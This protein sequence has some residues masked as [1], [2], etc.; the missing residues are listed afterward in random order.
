MNDPNEKKF[1]SKYIEIALMAS[2]FVIPFFG[3]Q[4]AIKNYLLVDHLSMSY[5]FLL[6]FIGGNVMTWLI[7]LLDGKSLKVKLVWTA[8]L[9]MMIAVINVLVWQDIQY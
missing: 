5:F 9:M 2:H 6:L 3:L 7:F 1:T 8:V 4:M